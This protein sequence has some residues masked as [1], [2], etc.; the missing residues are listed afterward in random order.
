MFGK[1]RR[2]LT[3]LVVPATE[4]TISDCGVV[5]DLSVGEEPERGAVV[6]LRQAR[7]GTAQCVLVHSGSSK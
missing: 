4:K 2:C 1:L 5:V 6:A 3:S 7:S